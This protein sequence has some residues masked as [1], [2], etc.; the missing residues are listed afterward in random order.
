[1]LSDAFSSESNKGLNPDGFL[2]ELS[3]WSRDIA[4]ELAERKNIPLLA[5]KLSMYESC[6]LLFGGGLSCVSRMVEGT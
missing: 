6:G 1:M 3:T 5:T 2:E 4:I